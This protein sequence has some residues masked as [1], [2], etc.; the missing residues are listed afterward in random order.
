MDEIINKL[1][2]K[3]GVTTDYLISELARYS[4]T[5]D[6]IG[7]IFWCGL[8]IIITVFF[9]TFKKDKL[10][11]LFGYNTLWTLAIVILT[12]IYTVTLIVVP[13]CVVDLI[14]WHISPIASAIKYIGNCF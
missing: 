1:C 7:I 13:Y 11:N 9:I 3:F 12:I 2:E 14:S 6:W 4:I 5:M 10:E 8:S